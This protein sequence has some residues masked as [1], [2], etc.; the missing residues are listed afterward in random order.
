MFCDFLAMEYLQLIR[1][2]F[3]RNLVLDFD[4]FASVCVV[5]SR[6]N[7]LC[8]VIICGVQHI[9]GTSIYIDKYTLI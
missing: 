8:V 4:I 2:I 1:N 6:T 3:I 7:F 9:Y 5:E